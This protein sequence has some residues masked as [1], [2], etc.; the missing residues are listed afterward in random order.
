MPRETAGAWLW[1]LMA[2]SLI[3]LSGIV[4]GILAARLLLPAGRG[5][6]AAVLFWPH[7]I[8]SV[9]GLSANEAIA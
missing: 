4:S 2:N 3:L 6:V 7:I 9:A 8:A 5:A 1:T